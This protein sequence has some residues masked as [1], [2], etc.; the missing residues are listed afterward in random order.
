MNNKALLHL[1]NEFA[2]IICFFVAAQLA[3]FYVATT[4]L[5]ISTLVALLAGW[6]L[7]RRLPILPIISGL[8]VLV[9]GLITLYYRAPDALIFADS[10]YYL[11]MGIT[12][13]GGLLF[14]ANLLKIIF[15][16]TFAMT[17][18]G[19]NILAR[20]WVLIFLLAGV[21]N[22]IA[23]FNLSPEEWVNFKFL[24]VITVA[25]F[26]I[27]QFTLARQHRLIGESNAWGLRIHTK[28]NN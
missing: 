11:L 22:E 28:D 12:I 23:R 20:R 8:F 9:S 5:I 26:G 25:S 13:G 24:K 6:Y 2:P 14:K 7:E 21:A 3:S 10:L 4:T 27:Y 18:L 15:A 16:T 19:W 17:D 1:L